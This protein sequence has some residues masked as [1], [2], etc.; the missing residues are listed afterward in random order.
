MNGNR[1]SGRWNTA[2]DGIPTQYATLDPE[3]P[4][5]EILRHEDLRRE[6]DAAHYSATLWQ[7]RVTSALIVDYGT[8]ELADA[9]GFPPA[10]LVEDDQER[11]RAEARRLIERGARGLLSPSA[12]LPGSTNL[13]LFGARVAVPW[14]SA[15]E[16][17]SAI[18]ARRLA[19]G[20]PPPGLTA[21]T[22]YFGQP[23]PL[24]AEYLRAVGGGGRQGRAAT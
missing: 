12:A 21:R 23:E 19:T 7:L 8:F 14:D 9:A 2:G 5:A 22:R 4:F 13:T 11:C 3:A 24:L 6:E 17:T 15:A 10:A 18:P 20:R 16:L 1:R